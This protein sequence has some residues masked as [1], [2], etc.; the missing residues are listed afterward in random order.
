ME[1]WSGMAT[2]PRPSLI[3]SRWENRVESCTQSRKGQ[4]SYCHLY[5]TNIELLP[6]RVVSVR[7]CARS[8]GFPDSYK[9]YGTPVEKYRQI[10][11][12]VPPALGKALGLA[13]RE[14]AG[15]SDVKAEK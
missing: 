5:C 14:A 2:S 12:A 9:F 8:Q 11:N 1:E 3:L 7:E 6:R 10:G 15:A 4:L 13:I